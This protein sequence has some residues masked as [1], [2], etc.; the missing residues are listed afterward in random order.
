LAGS[1]SSEE[2]KSLEGEDE[3]MIGGTDEVNVLQR[4]ESSS[5]QHARHVISRVKSRFDHLVISQYFVE[6]VLQRR[7]R[8][9]SAVF[10]EEMKVVAVSIE[11]ML[12]HSEKNDQ[13]DMKRCV[14]HETI[15][16]KT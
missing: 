6:S 5:R 8:E 9:A 15:A 13:H 4:I 12:V 10:L 2:A 7:I 16:V 14:H 11:R 1:Q 3:G